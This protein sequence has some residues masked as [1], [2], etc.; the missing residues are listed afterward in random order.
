MLTSINNGIGKAVDS[1]LDQ[2]RFLE[3]AASATLGVNDN[4]VDVTGFAAAVTV[5][6]PPVAEASGRMFAISVFGDAS[7]NTVTIKDQADS[8]QWVDQVVNTTNG[9][10]LLVYSDGRKYWILAFSA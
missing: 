10:E 5:T 8:I 2:S 1:K 7:I 6:L 9:G 3:I 4:I